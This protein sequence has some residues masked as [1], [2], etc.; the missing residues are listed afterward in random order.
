MVDMVTAT[1]Y[2]VES[3]GKRMLVDYGLF[4]ENGHE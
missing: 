2:L 3:A 4:V 1:R